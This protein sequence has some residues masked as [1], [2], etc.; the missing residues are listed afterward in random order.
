MKTLILT[1]KIETRLVTDLSLHFIPELC[2]FKRMS[3]IAMTYA[4]CI[5]CKLFPRYLL[6]ATYPI[7]VRISSFPK[8]SSYAARVFSLV[9]HSARRR[10][11]VLLSTFSNWFSPK[12][13]KIAF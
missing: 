6:K 9:F 3:H 10:E 7:F 1:K 8:R 11:E 5:V 12:V 4:Q 13:E 2:G